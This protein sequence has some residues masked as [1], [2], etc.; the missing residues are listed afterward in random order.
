L[1]LTLQASASKL[2][3]PDSSHFSILGV[4]IGQDTFKGV[5]IAS[6]TDS[7]ENV[8]LEFGEIGGGDVTG[9]YLSGQETASGCTFSL[10]ASSIE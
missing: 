10:L 9:F 5:D 6:Y 4:T 2:K 3:P 1:T 8:V 7:Q